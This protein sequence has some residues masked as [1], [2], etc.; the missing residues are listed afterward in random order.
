MRI[1]VIGLLCASLMTSCTDTPAGGA[2][3]AT[4]PAENLPSGV[5]PD[6]RL[7]D[8]RSALSEPLATGLRA[9]IIDQEGH[10]L[11]LLELDPQRF[12]PVFIGAVNTGISAQEALDANNLSVVI[13]S[14]FVT[15]LHSLQPVGLLK[16][17]GTTL[18]PLETY[19]YTRVLGVN[20]QGMSVVH[21]R[22]YQP[23]LFHS[24]LQAGPGIIEQSQLDISEQDLQRPKYFR[25]FVAICENRWLAGISLGPANLRTLGQTLL[26][27]IRESEWQC[28]EVVNLAGDREAV[29][30]IRTASNLTLFHG[31]PAS[32]KA[33]LLGFRSRSN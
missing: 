22:D 6:G 31:N 7:G 24:A 4:F 11:L 3:V 32:R 9:I 20:E 12:E 17:N 25:S 18:S 28:P 26:E 2:S 1:A 8:F 30:L 23:T 10:P 5:Q 21:K 14:S 13:G 16:I 33:G 15:E 19:G 29:A 27:F